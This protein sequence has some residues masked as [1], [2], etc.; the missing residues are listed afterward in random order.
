[1]IERDIIFFLIAVS[2]IAITTV[3]VHRE[4]IK[5]Y[6]QD[7]AVSRYSK[8]IDETDLG[9]EEVDIDDW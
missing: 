6:F 3:Y 2:L 7:K 5:L 1:M 9:L 4:D 8:S